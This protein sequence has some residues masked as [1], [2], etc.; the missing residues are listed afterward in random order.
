[1][2]IL[3]PVSSRLTYMPAAGH[4]S[5]DPPH[6]LRRRLLERWNMKTII[7]ILICSLL[8]VG[9]WCDESYH[10]ELFGVGALE[11]YRIALLHYN[12][13]GEWPDSDLVEKIALHTYDTK[14]AN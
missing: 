9:C 12:S 11:G 2:R 14:I 13:T 5:T 4:L 6:P 10:K 1:M 3:H 7:L 8:F